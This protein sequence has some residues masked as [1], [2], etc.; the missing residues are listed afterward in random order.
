MT[1]VACLDVSGEVLLALRVPCHPNDLKAIRECVDRGLLAFVVDGNV[2]TGSV[3]ALSQ[4]D[5]VFV[6]NPRSID[7][8]RMAYRWNP[9]EPFPRFEE[10]AVYGLSPL[11]GAF[12][13]VSDAVAF[14]EAF[15]KRY[16]GLQPKPFEPG[17]GKAGVDS[18]VVGMIRDECKAHAK[19]NGSTVY[20]LWKAANTPIGD[21][22]APGAMEWA[23]FVIAMQW[24]Y[25]VGAA[26]MDGII[27]ALA[28]E[29]L[30]ERAGKS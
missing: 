4:S 16:A 9:D 12:R 18:V 7:Q 25:N 17:L 6:L 20:D 3:L 10:V 23:Q 24:K 15:E 19:R 14:R 5:G 30:E 11:V 8:F 27:A 21:G 26:K 2:M 13:Q 29:D 28:N 1:A 22:V